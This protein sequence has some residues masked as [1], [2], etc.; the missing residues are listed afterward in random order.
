MTCLG[1]CCWSLLG[2]EAGDFS[3]LYPLYRMGGMAV[4]TGME[5][6]GVGKCSYLARKSLHWVRGRDKRSTPSVS[7]LS[8]APGHV[9]GEI[10][11]VG[12]A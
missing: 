6:N 3:F 5:V 12:V 7:D 2:V 8:G 1:G 4:E 11:G 9:E 10:S